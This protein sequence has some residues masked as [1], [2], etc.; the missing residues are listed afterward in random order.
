MWIPAYDR[1]SNHEQKK[2]VKGF[3]DISGW[4]VVVC[5]NK[6]PARIMIR[7]KR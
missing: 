2:N 4:E 7:K 5:G 3:Y 6:I 1:S